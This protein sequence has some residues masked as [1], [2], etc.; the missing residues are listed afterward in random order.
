[1]DNLR[2]KVKCKLKITQLNLNNEPQKSD[3]SFVI[4]KYK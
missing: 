4:M 1:M 2:L 3:F